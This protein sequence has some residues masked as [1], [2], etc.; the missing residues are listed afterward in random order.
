[1]AIL[2]QCPGSWK[3][4]RL[5]PPAPDSTEAAE[6][7][8][9][10]WTIAEWS[11]GRRPHVGQIAPNGV[12]VTEEMLEGAELWEDHVGT[13]QHVEERLPP[14]ELIDPDMWGT[15][16]GWSYRP[17]PVPDTN[18]VGGVITLADYKFGHRFVDVYKNWQLLSYAKL[19][20]DGLK[21]DGLQEQH[22]R[23]VFKIVQPRSY[24]VEGPVREWSCMASDL[25][26]EW[27]QIKSTIMLAKTDQAQCWVGPE[28][29]DCSARAFCPTLQRST[30][31]ALDEA[32]R[33]T[34]MALPPPALGLE[35]RLIG[36][37]IERLKA[38]E[39]GLKEEA[40]SKIRTGTSVPGFMT[41]A[42]KGRETWKVPVEQ[43]EA[44]GEVMGVAV[45]K[46]APLTPKQA[47]KAGLTKEL[48]DSFSFT[49]TG[50]LKLVED[51]G[52]FLRRTF[53]K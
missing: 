10:H 12:P 44:L 33:P 29:R 50:E 43:I 6:G 27:N 3:M 19:I 47:I 15:P 16:D 21:L 31:A 39:S 9:A 48:V 41:E 22:T 11:A 28:C 46:K 2:I 45:T 20:V 52:S 53:G 14:S 38:R 30:L 23:I 5:H 35:L 8:A 49:P 13:P 26:A 1:M 34:P 40:L 24:H 32:G 7:D 36:R 51:D 37:A 4:Q 42:G 18:V 25:R 17:I